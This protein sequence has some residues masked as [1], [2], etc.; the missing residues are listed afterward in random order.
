MESQPA[1]RRK[2]D[3]LKR[4][5]LAVHQI[6]F[7][8]GLV[9]ALG[10]SLV[11]EPL[12]AAVAGIAVFILINILGV[13]FRYAVSGDIQFFPRLSLVSYYPTDTKNKA[14]SN[15]PTKAREPLVGEGVTGYWDTKVETK[16]YGSMQIT[17]TVIQKGS[18][19]SGSVEGGLFAPM[20]IE[21][22]SIS[23]GR[24]TW[25][26]NSSGILSFNTSF[27]LLFTDDSLAGEVDF[28]KYGKG[29]LSGQKSNKTEV[30]DSAPPEERIFGSLAPGEISEALMPT[31]EELD[32]VDNCRQL[33]T[34]GWTIIKEAA[35]PEFFGRLRQA[36]IDCSPVVGSDGSRTGG[37][38][39]TDPVFAEAA[40][41]PKLMAMA[42]FSVGRG[43]LLGS[44]AST[45][46]EKDS[47]SLQLHA[48]QAYFPEPFSAHNMMLTC[49]WATDEFTLENGAT[50]VMPGT[51]ALLRHP[52][53]D[54]I[55][56]PKNLVS[57]DCPAG[58]IAI[59]D[60]R[61]WHGNA[62]KTTH[63]QRVVLHTTYQRMVVRPNEDFTHVEDEMIEQYGKPMAQLLGKS[64][65]IAKKDFDY[66][67]NYA[68]FIRTTN[69]A[70][71]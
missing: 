29:T 3:F 61:V 17:L 26:S 70:R 4:S 41:N 53:E 48:D 7:A 12:Y 16:A 55:K 66:V 23:D 30:A 69:N 25:K 60:G 18:A 11:T 27:D 10:T 14:G 52:N 28:G 58:S 8:L 47:T 36:I 33:A 37:L 32:L 15:T 68:T 19:L 50:T 46:R 1:T 57:M 64:D 63:G 38:L 62:E 22:G 45:V 34:E 39:E 49:C 71:F 44:M 2:E 59:W 51:N 9:V 31:L 35:D 6:C 56:T 43:F 24:A 65:S 13:A 40:M 5:S 21:D 20:D 54:E 67:E 42:E